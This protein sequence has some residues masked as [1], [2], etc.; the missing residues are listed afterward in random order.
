M[1]GTA[2]ARA[3]S[4]PASDAGRF[5]VTLATID[6][7]PEIRRLLREQ[8]LPGDITLSLE[9]EPDFRAAA[10]IEGDTH[11]TL[12]ARERTTR[13]LAAIASRSVRNAFLDGRPSRLGYFGQF[14]IAPPFRAGRALLGAGFAFARTLHLRGDAGVYLVSI[15]AENRAAR[16]LLTLLQSDAA[17]VFRPAGSLTTLAIPRRGQGL[18]RAN[19]F[20]IREGSADLLEDIAA[21]LSRNGRRYQF[22][23]CWT[24]D[25]LRSPE[26]TR[27]VSPDNFIVATHGG[28]VIGCA[29]CWD[30]RAFKQV[31]IRG[32]SPRLARWRPFLNVAG[33]W[34][35]VPKLPE[36][37][38]RLEFAYLSHVAVDD[39][40]TDVACALTSAAL[41]RCPA[42]AEFVV[43]G[44]ADGNPMLHELRKRFR[45][46]AYRTLLL[47]AFWPDG[48]RI[49]N[50]L[51]A[52]LP[53]P[54]VSI[55]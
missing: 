48:E 44:F 50:A 43:T 30:Q 6:D 17:P 28:R 26:R 22:A 27:G 10:A 38:R 31:V 55:L 54:E 45:H 2:A 41:S 3:L 34:A 1:A 53:H 11:E 24:A 19:P 14:R 46:R 8:A 33:R 23:P 5:E 42:D 52:R 40:R 37:G 35:G 47:V 49:V 20:E 39:D 32:Y 29:A 21:C 9:R 7:D 25:D 16:R 13:R 51:D 18:V 4:G 15:G 12:I 36:P